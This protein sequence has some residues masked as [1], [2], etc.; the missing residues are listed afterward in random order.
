MERNKVSFVAQVHS[1]FP[2]FKEGSK[3]LQVVEKGPQAPLQQPGYHAFLP[4]S[5]S[6]VLAAALGPIIYLFKNKILII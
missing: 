2:C 3:S 4:R 5:M 1:V 6:L